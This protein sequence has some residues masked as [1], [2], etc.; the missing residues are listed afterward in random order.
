MIDRL[1][2]N[3]LLELLSYFPALGIIGSRQVG[4]TTLVKQMAL[5]LNKQA[6]YLDLENPDD[7]SKLTEPSLFLRSYAD[8][9]VILDEIQR[10]PGLFPVLRSLIDE[11]R[12]PARFILTGSASPDLIRDSSESL[13]GRIAY[14][15]LTPLNI[16]E[17]NETMA[18]TRHWFRGGYPLSLLAPSDKLGRKW[19]ENYI[20]TY[21]ERDLPLLG[22]KVSPTVLRNLWTML[23]HIHGNILNMNVLSKSLEISSPTLKRYLHFLSE[24]FL[25]RILEPY[26]YNIKKRLVKSPKV[27]LRDTG[28]LHAI[29]GIP[30]PEQLSG[31]PVV[32]NSWEGYV[33]EQIYFHCR[34]ELG[35]YYYRTHQGAE[36]DLVLTKANRPVAAIEIKYTSAP[37]VTKGL[38]ISIED[39]KTMKNYIICPADSD[40]PIAE[41][42]TVC[43][44]MS[45]IKNHLSA[46]RDSLQNR[47]EV[48]P[49]ADV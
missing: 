44:V 7:L 26:H 34:N 1:I 39:L 12:T 45:F 6:I 15:E 25:L 3:E 36:C 11:N 23:A 4:K 49:S 42:I 46:I 31:N 40:Y 48:S 21:I 32:G 27:F 41:N 10:M 29:L 22:L 19:L 28:I 24:A 14:K 8:R 38:M 18:T 2:K 33:I 47:S 16:A 9:C 37:K 20:Q 35:L 17:V 13:A 5:N 30:A 43:S